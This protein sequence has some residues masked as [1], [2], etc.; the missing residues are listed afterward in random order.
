MDASSLTGSAAAPPAGGDRH[1][2]DHLLAPAA[3]AG[4]AGPHGGPH[5]L[6]PLP[7][8]QQLHLRVSGDPGRGW[9]GGRV[10]GSGGGGTC[11][12][13]ADGGESGRRWRLGSLALVSG[14]LTPPLIPALSPPARFCV[15][16]DF[17]A[18]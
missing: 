8:L 15:T 9:G 13:A 14:R 4:P 16:A 2:Q 3:D 10:E 17:G 12:R 5:Q 7:R 1:G 6:R 11:T 18:R